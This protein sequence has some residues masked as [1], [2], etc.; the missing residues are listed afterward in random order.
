MDEFVEKSRSNYFRVKSGS[1]FEK[2]CE[3]GD[4][5]SSMENPGFVQENLDSSFPMDTVK[6]DDQ[7]I[8]SKKPSRK[9]W[10]RKKSVLSG[11]L[12][13]NGIQ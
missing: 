2:L 11:P 7:S 6:K 12:P 10:K 9:F 3:N 5:K 4:W 13:M 8:N 1:E